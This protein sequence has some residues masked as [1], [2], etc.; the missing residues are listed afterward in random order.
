MATHHP[1]RFRPRGLTTL[2]I[3][4]ILLVVIGGLFAARIAAEK[5]KHGKDR[6]QCLMNIRN[7]QTAMRS[8]G[9]MNQ[10]ATGDKLDWKDLYL[11]PGRMLYY[12]PSCP[13]GGTYHFANEVTA[14]GIPY[15]TCSLATSHDHRPPSTKG[16]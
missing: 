5:W 12:M 7:A 14:A 13:G 1:S 10:L 8:Y 16:W 6:S 3:L 4:V 15:M 11:G 2:E 9:G